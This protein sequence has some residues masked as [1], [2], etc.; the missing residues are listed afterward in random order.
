MNTIDLPA[1]TV[2]DWLTYELDRNH[3]YLWWAIPLMS[4]ACFFVV[5]G[6]VNANTLPAIVGSAIAGIIIGTVF[7]LLPAPATKGSTHD[8]DRHVAFQTEK[9]LAKAGYMTEESRS[10]W[11][12][13]FASLRHNGKPF[14]LRVTD[15]NGDNRTVFISVEG[16]DLLV[17]VHP[18]DAKGDQ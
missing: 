12:D 5:A 17:E 14:T 7:V 10:I 6:F 13:K 1:D 11:E 2:N 9:A 4:I 16:D 18:D 8:V 15:R 3:H